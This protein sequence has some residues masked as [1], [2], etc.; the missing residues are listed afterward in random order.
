MA[1]KL[2]DLA[3]QTEE[4]KYSLNLPSQD[5]GL[6]DIRS[7]LAQP[8]VMPQVEEVAMPEVAPAA[9]S[10]EDYK[11]LLEKAKQNQMGSNLIANLGQIGTE[12]TSRMAGYKPDTSIY[13]GM[14]QQ[15]GMDV[16]A[17]N[18][19]VTRAEEN[20][21]KLERAKE[22]AQRTL[23]IK[24]AEME[25]KKEQAQKGQEF[26]ADQERKDRELK[27]LIADMNQKDRAA[28]L[29][30]QQGKAEM[31]GPAATD[32]VEAAVELKNSLNEVNKY[33]GEATAKGIGTNRPTTWARNLGE[34]IGIPQD[35][36]WTNLQT[37]TGKTLAAYMKLMSGAAVAEPE[38][39]RLERVFPTTADTPQAL[40]TKLEQWKQ[41]ADRQINNKLKTQQMAGKNVDSLINGLKAQGL[42]ITVEPKGGIF[43]GSQG[44]TTTQQSPTPAT[45][46]GADKYDSMSDEELLAQRKAKLGK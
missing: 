7:T 6:E 2:T 35:S 10:L 44:T 3:K 30:F 12:Y 9:P 38:V 16:G 32:A 37:A 25:F 17:A 42:N 36:S 22:L 26:K 5:T 11:T 28:A 43:S 33:A 45:T 13:E 19:D 34:S 4:K 46:K 20:A 41:D 23:T 21:A 8:Q 15:A 27:A 29:A 1:M 40:V 39:K 31:I 14:R 24:Q 18:A